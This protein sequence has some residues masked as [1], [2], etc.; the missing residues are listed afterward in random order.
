M[1]CLRNFQL[2][3]GRS[4]D[5]PTYPLLAAN[6]RRLVILFAITLGGPTKDAGGRTMASVR[7]LAG[8]P[9]AATGDPSRSQVKE[10]R[11]VTAIATAS[12]SS[13]LCGSDSHSFRFVGTLKASSGNHSARSTAVECLLLQP[14]CLKNTRI[15]LASKDRIWIDLRCAPLLMLSTTLAPD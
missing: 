10:V 2:C 4:A 9:K 6:Q 11:K 12:K 5:T 3:R 7:Q 15:W 1:L 13:A 8:P 14:R